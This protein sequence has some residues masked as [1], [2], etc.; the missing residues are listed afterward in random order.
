MTHFCGTLSAHSYLSMSRVLVGAL[1]AL[2]GAHALSAE[3]ARVSALIEAHTG[4][5][6]AQMRSILTRLS[7]AA[8]GGSL[9]DTMTS[10]QDQLEQKVE[11]TIKRGHAAAQAAITAKADKVKVLTDKLVSLKSIADQKDKQSQECVTSEQKALADVEAQEAK[12]AEFKATREEACAPLSTLSTVQTQPELPKFSCV[13]SQAESCADQMEEFSGVI[14][15]LIKDV[16]GRTQK[17]VNAWNTAKKRCDAATQARDAH[18]ANAKSMRTA[19]AK[20]RAACATVREGLESD[21]CAVGTTLQAKCAAVSDYKALLAKVK[22]VKGDANSHPDRL[23]E[24]R[25]TQMAKC[26]AGAL[27]RG[28]TVNGQVFKACE[29]AVNF[30]KDVGAFDNKEATI[31]KML[32]PA[33]FT[34]DEKTVSFAGGAWRVPEGKWIS[35]EG[36]YRISEWTPTVNLNEG[37]DAFDFCTKKDPPAPR[38]RATPPA[39]SLLQGGDGDAGCSTWETTLPG[40]PL[41]NASHTVVMALKFNGSQAVR[42]QWIFNLGQHGTGANHWLWNQHRGQSKIQFGAW[43]GPQVGEADISSTRTMSS[44]YD[45]E[46]GMYSLYLDG[47]LTVSRKTA[48]NI[49]TGAMDVGVKSLRGEADFAGCIYAVQ[50]YAAALSDWQVFTAGQKILGA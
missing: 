35:S 12:T 32:T 30:N 45:G 22:K 39:G 5:E 33:T 20:R 23:N 49:R 11:S 15:N 46:T 3:F 38:F 47:Q 19:W 36:Y 2:G 8:P 48:L 41:G 31:K 10:L 14:S 50:V 44:V 28:E 9:Q 18:I 34:C 7:D 13:F 29:D 21:M 1:A 17:G 25:V 42:R 40:K 26:V 37:E 43:N 24:W 6:N 4:S 16:T 27:S